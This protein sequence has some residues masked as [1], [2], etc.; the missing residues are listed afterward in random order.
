MG[1]AIIGRSRDELFDVFD[2]YAYERKAEVDR[3]DMGPNTGMLKSY[4]L[5]TSDRGHAVDVEKVLGATQWRAERVGRE[6]LYYVGGPQGVVGYAE[7]L[8]SRYIVL[9]SYGKTDPTDR[10]VRRAVMD[11]PDLDFLW[12]AGETFMLLW[13]QYILPKAPSSF[14][15]IKCEQRNS[16]ESHR[17]QDIWYDEEQ[18]Q[19]D[20]TPEGDGDD[21][22]GGADRRA[23][24]SAFTERAL[25]LEQILSQF[26]EIYPA[27]R[28][29]KM[30][31]FPGEERGGYDVWSWG[32]MT[33][34]AP[35]FREGRS[36]L[37]EIARLYESVTTAIEEAI[38]LNLET[39]DLPDGPSLRIGGAPVIFEFGSP[40][41][42]QTFR[43]LVSTTFEQGRGPLRLWGNPISL[44]ER[45]VHV[46]GLDLHLWQRLYMELTP[47][48]FL[49][50]LPRG[51]CGNTVHRLMTNIQRFVDPAVTMTIG[52]TAYADLFENALLG[53]DVLR[54]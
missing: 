29:V 37:V 18:E 28:A 33:H 6:D 22:A 2:N 50:L 15:S 7:P 17:A 44:G 12:L 52:D 32:K 39:V 35:N 3:Y 36:R 34:R 27:F 54:A 9:H 8:G 43:N 16:F 53:R 24:S 42:D 11:S 14:V 49:F 25:R 13:R 31:R 38:W 45:K 4:V 23:T 30:L 20:A 19:A 47:Q 5:E 46:Y 48:R 51:T 40:L 26:Q 1:N 41:P 10:A 21:E